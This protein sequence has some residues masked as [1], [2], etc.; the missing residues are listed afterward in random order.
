L[1]RLRPGVTHAAA[2]ADLLLSSRNSNYGILPIFPRLGELSCDV[3]GRPFRD[4]SD[5]LWI[6]F[7]AVGLLLVIACANVSNLLLSKMASRQKEISIRAAL[8]AS[9]DG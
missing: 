1:G 7:G 8:G 2:E 5:A 4:I 6:L 3:Q 9:A